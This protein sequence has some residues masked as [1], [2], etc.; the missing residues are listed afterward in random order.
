MEENLPAHIRRTIAQK[1]LKFYNI[2]AVKIAT[3][4]GLEGRISMIMQTAF[5]KLSNVIPVDEAMVYLKKE[6]KKMF[7]KKGDPVVN[8]NITATD[9]TM[10][11]LIEV[12]YPESWANAEDKPV[13]ISDKK[14]TGKKNE[15]D[16]FFETVMKPIMAQKGD[17]L[18]VSAFRPDGIFPVGTTKYE[19]RGV[20]I[21]VPE[22]IPENCIQCNQCAMVCPHAAIRPVLLTNE[23]KEKCSGNFYY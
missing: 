11:N 1:K 12:K 20:A 17:T 9:K 18:P 8:M 22:W 19:K 16:R 6:I 14:D 3:E 5:F 2:D 15:A 21:H 4:V 23:E 10:D 13:V 7:D